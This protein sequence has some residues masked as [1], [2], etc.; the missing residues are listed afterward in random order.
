[1]RTNL[2]KKKNIIDEYLK[3]RKSRKLIELAV[4]Q[5]NRAWEQLIENHKEFQTLCSCDKE[6]QDADTWLIES[7]ALVE[8]VICGTFEYQ[9]LKIDSD[10]S[11]CSVPIAPKESKQIDSAGN[12]SVASVGFQSS[13]K[14]G[15]KISKG[16][17]SSSRARARAVAREVDLLN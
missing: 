17:S 10:G 11:E 16:T 14:S 9:K 2:T 3:S 4:T 5:L 7:Q 15:S 12:T 6:L 13:K 1:M 8:D